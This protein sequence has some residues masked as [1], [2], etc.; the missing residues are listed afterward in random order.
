MKRPCSNAN[1]SADV[2]QNLSQEPEDPVI[3]TLALKPQETMELVSAAALGEI[4]LT[5]RPQ[6]PSEEIIAETDYTMQ[7]IATPQAP[8]LAPVMPSTAP[9]SRVTANVP[10]TSIPLP[11]STNAA[12][13]TPGAQGNEPSFEII[14][15]DKIIGK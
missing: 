8:A 15:G 2:V 3:A 11:P 13:T 1:S 6:N 5:L 9:T 4:Y 7:G 14:Q 12:T 10:S